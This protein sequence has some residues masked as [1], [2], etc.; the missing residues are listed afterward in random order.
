V[1]VWGGGNTLAQA[2]WQVQQERT[3]DQLKAFLHKL[4]VYTI[5]D[6]DRGYGN[7]PYD[8]SSHYWMRKDFKDDLF[9][10]WDESAWLFQNSTGKANWDKYADQI[11]NHGALGTLYPKF[12]W[13]V[14]GDTPSFLYVM[15]NGLNNPEHPTYGGWGGTFESGISP[16]KQTFAFVNQ[17]GT[18]AGT[19]ARKYESRF[20]PAVFN[21]FAARMDWAKDGR[22]NRNPQVNVNG[23]S[24]LTSILL[25]PAP[26][27]KVP[28]DASASR[29]P[30]GDKLNFSWW[31]MTEAGTYTEDIKISGSDSDHATVEVPSDSAGKSFHLICEVTD[32]G[33]PPLTSYRRIIFEPNV[34]VP[35]K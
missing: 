8:G 25:T 12:K 27:D 32:D 1:G 7:T 6:Q 22:G 17:Q 24:N 9:F 28:F 30:D 11:Q 31:V 33:I 19:T 18:Q 35:K 21:N 14:E 34:P 16:D 23:N 29:D 13:G 15:P 26:G 3:P 4:R 2:I 5:T 20:Y 10:V